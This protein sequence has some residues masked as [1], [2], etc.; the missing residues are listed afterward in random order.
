MELVEDPRLFGMGDAGASV[1][2]RERDLGINAACVDLDSC[3]ARTEPHGIREEVRDDSAD[4]LR[5]GVEDGRVGC[6]VYVESDV[7][8]S[9][10]RR[11][12]DVSAASTRSAVATLSRCRSTRAGLSPGQIQDVVDQREQL[13]TGFDDVV[14][15]A[16]LLR[17]EG[18]E[19]LL[20]Q[21]VREADDRIQRRAQLVTHVRDELGLVPADPIELGPGCLD[22]HARLVLGEG[23]GVQLAHEPRHREG[24]PGPGAEEQLELHERQIVPGL[25]D[26]SDAYGR[27]DDQEHH[28]CPPPRE[29]HERRHRGPCVRWSTGHHHQRARPVGRTAQHASENDPQDG[30]RAD[31][32]GILEAAHP[33]GD[34]GTE[35]RGHDET[36]WVKARDIGALDEQ[37][38]ERDRAQGGASDQEPLRD[39]RVAAHDLVGGG[40]A[41]TALAVMCATCSRSRPARGRTNAKVLP[42]PS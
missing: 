36:L 12:C 10:L 40:G 30:V 38:H 14:D 37:Q 8:S 3:A 7:S 35:C 22:R 29:D 21:H 19:Q 42:P 32:E 17:V 26:E 23:R 25:E 27:G 31:R 33:Q 15:V 24:T 4:A 16:G 41:G 28:G 20:P 5:I 39:A 11:V 2:D 18:A 13:A 6:D 9:G 34:A 1:A